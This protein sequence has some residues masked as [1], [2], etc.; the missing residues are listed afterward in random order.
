MPDPTTHRLADTARTLVLDTEAYEPSCGRLASD[1]PHRGKPLTGFA[2]PEAF[3]CDVHD[4]EGRRHR[5][6]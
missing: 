6:A 2:R 1:Q 3:D 5:P 4:V